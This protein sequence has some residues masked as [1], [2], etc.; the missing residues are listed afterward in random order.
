MK[1]LNAVQIRAWDQYT[2]EHEPIMSIDLMERAAAKCFEWLDNNGW[3]VY[4]FAVFCGKG[5][6]GG[7]GLAIARMLAGRGCKVSVYILEFGHKGT[8]D[9]PTNLARLYQYP[10]VDIHFIQDEN[11]FHPLAKETIV[12]DALFGTAFTT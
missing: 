1:I 9:F 10:S 5:N 8:E 7:D 4:S 11:N 3:L 2:M 12:I 6:N